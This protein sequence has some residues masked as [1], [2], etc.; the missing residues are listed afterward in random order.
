LDGTLNIWATN[1]NFT[2]PN[3]AVENAHVKNT[4]TSSLHYAPDNKTLV[5][6]GGD[7]TVKRKRYFSLS[8]TKKNLNQRLIYIIL[9]VWD[10][11]ALKTP[12]AVRDGMTTL[13]PETNVTFSPD[14]QYILTGVSANPSEGL[15]GR[16]VLL[17][18]LNLEIFRT[19]GQLISL[20]FRVLESCSVILTVSVSSS[21]HITC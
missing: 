7:D 14:N 3:A 17:D 15:G 13:N 1:S 8:T 11:R 10:V 20:H 21:S 2:R 4:E 5:S 19:I 16:V 9:I 6:R 18:K 12:L